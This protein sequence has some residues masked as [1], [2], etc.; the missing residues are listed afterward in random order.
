M[1]F[2]IYSYAATVLIFCGLALALYGVGLVLGRRSA[3]LSARDCKAIG[4]TILI[5][6]AVT[7]PEEYLALAWRTW[8]YNPERTFYTTFLGAEV[9]TYLFIILVSLVVSIAT[10]V[11]ANREDRKRLQ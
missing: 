6:T 5:M 9:E 10:L 4:I 7:G 8:I 3:R 2:G 11:Y 1:D